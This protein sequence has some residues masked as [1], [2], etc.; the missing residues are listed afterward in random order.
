MG[1]YLLWCE[2]QCDFKRIIKGGFLLLKWRRVWRGE[3]LCVIIIRNEGRCAS[4]THLESTSRLS[5]GM[6]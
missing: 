2:L 5:V 4:K 1:R 6:T 3:V